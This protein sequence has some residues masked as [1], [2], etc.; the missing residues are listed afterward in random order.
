M[1]NTPVV[2]SHSIYS[3][4]CTALALTRCRARIMCPWK[5][6]TIIHC[7]MCPALHCLHMLRAPEP[8]S[9]EHSLLRNYNSHSYTQVELFSFTYWPYQ[10]NVIHQ[11]PDSNGQGTYAGATVDII[12]LSGEILRIDAHRATN[13]LAHGLAPAQTTHVY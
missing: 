6:T 5:T 3:L 9:S 4:S 2:T 8:L 11:P 7:C 13:S 1:L 12:L 10:V